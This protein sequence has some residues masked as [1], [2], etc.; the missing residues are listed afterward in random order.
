MYRFQ[1][2][3]LQRS[4]QYLNFF[5]IAFPFFT[6]RK[7]NVRKQYIFFVEKIFFFL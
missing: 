2:F 6:P 3:L 1:L 5:P 7:R 4:L